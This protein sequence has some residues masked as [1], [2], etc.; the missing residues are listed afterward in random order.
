[1]VNYKNI[2][3]A[4]YFAKAAYE[5]PSE[6][7]LAHFDCSGDLIDAQ[8]TIYNDKDTLFV[9][10][11][12]TELDVAQDILTDTMYIPTPLFRWSW[13]RFWFLKVGCFHSGFMIMAKALLRTLSVEK[14]YRLKEVIKNNFNKKKVVLTGHSM[15][16]AVAQILPFLG[17]RCHEVITFGA[18]QCVR[19]ASDYPVDF[20]NIVNGSD[21]V[22]K[23]DPMNL[24]RHYGVFI[25]LGQNFDGD[26]SELIKDHSIQL[27]IDEI[28]SLG[29]LGD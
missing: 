13:H 20:Y 1:M 12:G 24:Y 4:A 16:G 8:C 2:L 21:I 5:L 11:R 10:I 19:L 15:G 3:R 6:D 22:P 17:I 25:Q 23:I 26:I 27:Y 29:D 18:P 28:E 7:S 14:G 9:A